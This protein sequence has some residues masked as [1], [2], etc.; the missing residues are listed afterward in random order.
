MIKR[1]LLAILLLLLLVGAIAGVKV[2]QIRTMMNPA[3]K[4]A[5]APPPETVTTAEI[6]AESWETTVTAVGSLSAVQGVMVASEIS[7]KIELIAFQP[8]SK[9][10]KGD[11]LVKLETSSEEVQLQAAE[12]DLALLKINLD[13]VGKLLAQKNI[14]QADYDL[15]E[16]K[17]KVALA[18]SDAIRVAILKKHIRAP[19]SGHLGVRL[20]NE[21]HILKDGEA[22]VSLQ[23]LDPIYVNILLPQQQLAQIKP[24][25]KVRILS[26]VLG[27]TPVEG[28][29]STI[30]PEVDS[31]T[32]NVKIQTT[33]A[34]PK[35]LLLPGMFVDVAVVLPAPQAVT[36]IPVTAVL[37]APYSDSVF[38]VEEKKEEEGAGK[39]SLALRQQ[40]V[41]LGEKRGDFVAVLSG[42]KEGEKVVS[43]GVF[44][45]RNG[46]AVVVNNSLRPN[47]SKSPKPEDK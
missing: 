4:A 9:V 33:L 15:A 17:H 32:R 38:V 29:I 25:M 18:Q 5:S 16:A 13:R 44:K 36:V 37:P 27:G 21:G 24:G 40:F 11:L 2:Q 22:I 41:R 26:E 47:F 14:A 31:A 43:T 20:V 30:N 35:E 23:S 6:T 3:L 28:K 45:L 46:Q 7:G 10:K 42:L 8:G 1:I 12:A 39:G 19:F 34:N